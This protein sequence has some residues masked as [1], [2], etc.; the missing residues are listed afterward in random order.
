[1]RRSFALKFLHPERSATS[2]Y[3]GVSRMRLDPTEGDRA[4]REGG[5]TYSSF[6]AYRWSGQLS[7]ERGS[8]GQLATA[9]VGR[10][11]LF[12]LI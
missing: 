10:A 4:L 5:A 3:W 11:N 2:R 9:F 6:S 7:V 8:S 1:M 12:N